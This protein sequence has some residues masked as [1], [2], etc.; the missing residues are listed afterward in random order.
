[1]IQL[2]RYMEKLICYY[3]IVRQWIGV[4][5]MNANMQ[6]A[7]LV[8][9]MVC[10]TLLVH[11]FGNY[12]A[13]SIAL[14]YRFLTTFVGLL[15]CLVC[16]IYICLLMLSILVLGLTNVILPGYKFI[17]IIVCLGLEEEACSLIFYS[18]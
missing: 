8:A 13:P 9:T 18:A 4:F 16:I 17:K 7:Q 12:Y 2:Y 1:M 14:K 10:K 15:S 3:D 6:S 5:I 11:S